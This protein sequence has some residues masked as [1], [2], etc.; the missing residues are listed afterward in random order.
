M[1]KFTIGLV[2]K[3][4][5]G[6]HILEE[7]LKKEKKWLDGKVMIVT[8]GRSLKKHGYLD[9]LQSILNKLT[10]R[11]DILIYENVS[12]NPRL[13]EVKQAVEIGRREEVTTIIG[14]GGGSALDAAKAV[15]AGIG[16]DEKLEEYL[17]TEKEPGKK[18]LPIICIP[19]T[20]GTGSELSKG[21]ILTSPVHHIKAGIR[22]EN[23]LPKAAIIDDHFTWTV[24][25]KITM[26]TGFDVLAH[27]IESY[28]AVKANAYSEM[29]SEKTIQIIAENLKILANDLNNH[30]ARYQMCFASMLMGMNLANIG[31]CLPHRMQYPIGAN[32]DT[33]HPAGLA[34]I[35]PAWIR[36]EYEVN[37]DKINQ[38][39]ALLCHSCADTSAQAVKLFGEY[40]NQLGIAYRLSDLGVDSTMLKEL[41]QQVTGNIANDKLAGFP[42]VIGRIFRESI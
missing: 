3:I 1:K 34:A 35:Y 6:T 14:F 19:T 22:G 31:T 38:V 13:E 28:V 29:L 33:S 42:E 39:L 9:E 23:I 41:E 24:P 16:N 25:E 17:L 15:A 27:A 18:T 32:T 21:A 2:T 40:M 26:E 10:D 8:T 5:F 37:S 20:A 36:Y 30:N 11:D 7:A 12:Q 4:Y